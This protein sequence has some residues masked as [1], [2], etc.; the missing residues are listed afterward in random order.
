MNGTTACEFADRRR[1]PRERRSS[2]RL[3]FV[4]AVRQGPGPAPQLSQAADLG[5]FGMQV[6]RCSG[7]PLAGPL[8][9]SFALPDGGAELLQLMAEV[10]FDRPS[11]E[12]GR[13]F[14]TGLRFSQMSPDVEDRL[15]LFLQS[16]DG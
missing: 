8:H 12:D 2:R 16:Q 4:A 5:L 9:L 15:R 6:R 13:Y 14:S 10:V 1:A 11:S 3:P 7:D